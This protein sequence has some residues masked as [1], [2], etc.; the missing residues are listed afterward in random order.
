MHHRYGLTRF[1]T[2]NDN[3]INIWYD[4]SVAF[5]AYIMMLC[6]NLVFQS[7]A[8]TGVFPKYIVY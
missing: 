7:S 1:P 6:N 8:A 4:T 2:N 3:T 5:T